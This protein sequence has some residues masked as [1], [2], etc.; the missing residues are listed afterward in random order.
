MGDQGRWFKLWTSAPADDDL[1]ALSPDL[2]WAWAAFGAYTK[3]H[4][5][6]GV[7]SVNPKNAA[8]AAQLGVS[9]EAILDTLKHLP[10]MTVE[11]GKR[12][13]GSAV[14]TWH[15]W[16]KYQE[17]STVSKRVADLRSKRR[18]EESKKRR[19]KEPPPVILPTPSV[20][21]LIP[22]SILEAL[23]QSPLLGAVAALRSQS[24]WRAEVRANEGVDF[25]KEVLKAEA[26]LVANPSRAGKKDWVK[27][28]H[29][30]LARADREA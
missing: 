16:R 5:T 11:E 15:N 17:D 13:N 28:M 20:E 2:R 7:V 23:A 6:R 8:L 26:W 24:F 4:G 25:G 22:K 30:W 21:F 18:G 29:G 3:L 19:D 9:P 14:V 27:F 10:H 12:A 1:Q